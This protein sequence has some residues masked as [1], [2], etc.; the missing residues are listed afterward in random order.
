MFGEISKNRVQLLRDIGKINII[1]KCSDCIFYRYGE[2]TLYLK[3]SF[4]KRL[5]RVCPLKGQTKIVIW[6]Y[7]AKP[8][9]ESNRLELDCRFCKY[10]DGLLCMLDRCLRSVKN[11]KWSCVSEGKYEV[12][13]W[14]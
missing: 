1:S 2:C 8:D 11:E 9:I 5:F 4:W 14:K 12:F 3:I 7:G 10:R 6:K 13:E